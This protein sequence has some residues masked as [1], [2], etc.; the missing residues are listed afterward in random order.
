MKANKMTATG[1]RRRK[2]KPDQPVLELPPLSDDQFAALR[3]NIG[4]NGVLVPILLDEDR[5]IIDGWHRYRIATELGY[6]CP[7]I[8]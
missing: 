6:E 3:E 4:I 7:E 8:I 2:K 1:N 5:Q